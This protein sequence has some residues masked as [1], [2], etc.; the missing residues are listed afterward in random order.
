MWRSSGTIPG[1]E[2]GV[3]GEEVVVHVREVVDG[4][5]PG[6]PQPHCHVS[7]CLPPP[8][9]DP[10]TKNEL[11]AHVETHPNPHPHPFPHPYPHPHLTLPPLS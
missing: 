4:E 5:T 7:S 6:N 9:V 1:H 8:G 11:W 10:G 3:D 2:A